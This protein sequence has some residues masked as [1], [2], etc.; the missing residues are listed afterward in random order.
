[1]WF[2]GTLESGETLRVRLVSLRFIHLKVGLLAG[3]IYAAF[4]VSLKKGI[5]CSQGI[6]FSLWL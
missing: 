5:S 2:L 3:V 1:M 6:W 4:A